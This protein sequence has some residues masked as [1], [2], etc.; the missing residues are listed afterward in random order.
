M[1]IAQLLPRVSKGFRKTKA[2]IGLMLVLLLPS[3]AASQEPVQRKWGFGWDH[4]LSARMWIDGHWELSVAAGPDDYL[5]KTETRNWML[6]APPAHHGL[7]EIP[8]DIREEHGWV[9]IQ[10]GRLIKNLDP[11]SIVGYA[12]LTY[13]W[14]VRQER[15][16]T[17]EGLNTDFDT[18]ELDRHTQRWIMTLGF[19]PAWQPTS[20]L[21]VE[22]AFGLNFIIENWDQSSYQTYAG[23]S[24][25][26]YQE[27][28]GHGQMF[29]DFGL[30]GLSS[31]QVFLWF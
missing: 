19:R 17:L 4:G 13:E 24:G 31:I 22:A 2:C 16:L 21:T 10:G 20:F 1:K 15:S 25:H 3:L 6:N 28:D 14:I 30:E 11:F 8:E 9:R 23:V 26:D 27:L 18:F 12:G 7:L 5:S 29:Q